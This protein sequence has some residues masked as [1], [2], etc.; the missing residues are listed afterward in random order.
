MG[1]QGKFSFT[2]NYHPHKYRDEIYE[3]QKQW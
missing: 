3:K 2:G 1:F